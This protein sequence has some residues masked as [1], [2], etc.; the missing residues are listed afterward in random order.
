MADYN[1]ANDKTYGPYY[2]QAKDAM[3]GTFATI[4]RDIFDCDYFKNKYLPQYKADPE[5][6]SLSRSLQTACKGG[7]D[8][9]D[10]IVYRNLP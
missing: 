2:Q 4:E 1:I 10:P 8:K 9:A 5:N 3:L 7:C 6:K